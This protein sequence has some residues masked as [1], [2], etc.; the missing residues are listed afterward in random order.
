M[1]VAYRVITLSADSHLNVR[2]RPT[3]RSPVVG[4]LKSGMGGIYLKK[5]APHG[6]WCMIDV[7]NVRGWVNMRYLGGY[8]E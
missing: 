5:C 2:S 1:E 4:R 7:E 3:T 6:P 8:A